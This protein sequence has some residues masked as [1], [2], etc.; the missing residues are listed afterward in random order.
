MSEP[1]RRS[2]LVDAMVTFA[3][4]FATVLGASVVGSGCAT[5]YGGPPPP[6]LETK[7]G[8]PA[9]MAG[10]AG[11]AGTVSPRASAPDSR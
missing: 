6:P 3:G 5:K 2:F 4:V 7:Y 9:E 8:G 10:A 11:S 1:D